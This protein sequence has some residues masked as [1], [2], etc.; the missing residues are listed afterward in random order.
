MH[1]LSGIMKFSRTIEHPRLEVIGQWDLGIS[2]NFEMNNGQMFPK[3]RLTRFDDTR[4]RFPGNIA[5][6]T[7]ICCNPTVISLKLLDF[8]RFTIYLVNKIQLKT[9]LA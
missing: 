8:Y 9:W 1:R 4:A 5:Y 7:K 2:R 3:L 6:P